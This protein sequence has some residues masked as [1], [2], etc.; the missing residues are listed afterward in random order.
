MVWGSNTKHITSNVSSLGKEPAI[1]PVKP[2][3]Q[4]AALSRDA[5]TETWQLPAPGWSSFMT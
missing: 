2:A 5:A 1:P 4:D 3:V